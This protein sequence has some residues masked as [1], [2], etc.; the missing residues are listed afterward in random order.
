NLE[1]L[2]VP[3]PRPHYW[4]ED[5]EIAVAPSIGIAISKPNSEAE[6]PNAAALLIG[7]PDYKGTGYE[8]LPGAGA[9]LDQVKEC[10]RPAVAQVY[11]RGDASPE[12]YWGANPAR[13]QFI[14][15]AAH[16]ESN[17][18]NPLDSAVVLSRGGGFK[19]YAR[20]VID[21]PIRADLVTLSA[22]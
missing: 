15:F 12:A 11:R 5:V 9:E 16:A 2:V 21:V 10:L 1:T 6:R 14:H 8:P 3:E 4:I 7:D 13:F 17:V 18:K 19:L 22:C 20:D